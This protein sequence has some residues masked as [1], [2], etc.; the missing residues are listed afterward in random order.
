MKKIE[1]LKKN[2]VKRLG[3]IDV[4]D[5]PCQELISYI[6]A[7]RKEDELLKPDWRETYMRI[8]NSSEISM[9]GENRG[10]K[11]G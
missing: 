4:A 6:D 5:M 7:L 1:S 9:G 3:E 8:M 10:D 2:A 11:N